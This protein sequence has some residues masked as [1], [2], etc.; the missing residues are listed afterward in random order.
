MAM[1]W[2]WYLHFIDMNINCKATQSEIHGIACL[3]SNYQNPMRTDFLCTHTITA[4]LVEYTFYTSGTNDF[5]RGKS[6]CM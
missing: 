3:I 6:Q 4:I 5:S 1:K 2:R